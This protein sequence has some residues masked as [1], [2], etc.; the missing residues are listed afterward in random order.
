MKQFFLICLCAFILYGCGINQRALD[1]QRRALASDYTEPH[2]P[3]F[4]FTP[5]AKWMNDPNGMVYFDGEYHLFYQY[6]PDST[7]WGPMHWG[8]AVSEDLIHWEHLPIA[9]YPDER[10][11]IF[12]GSAVIDERNSSGLGIANM[13]PMVAI[14]T[15]HD[16]ES[17]KAGKID[18]QTQGIAYS[19]NDG[20]D[21]NKYKEN[22]VLENPGIE[23]FRN[24]KVMWYD[25]N[26]RWV[27]SLAVKDKISFY[28]S[29]NLLD[30]EHTGDFGTDAGAHGGVWECPDL[31]PLK[32]EGS[33]EVKWVLLVSIN[34]GGPNKG[35]A[36]Q[37]FVGDFDGNEFIP[38]PDWPLSEEGVWIDYGRD[39]YAGVTWYMGP[40]GDKRRIFMGWMSN[41]DYANEVPTKT[42]RSAMTIPR[43]L[44]LAETEYGLRL[45]SEPVPELS[46]LYKT[47]IAIQSQPLDTAIYFSRNLKTNTPTFDLKLQLEALSQDSDFYLELS[48]AQDQKVLIG[49]DGIR[50]QYYIDRTASGNHD[51]SDEFSGVQWGPRMVNGSNFDLRFL[52]DVASVEFFADGGKTTMTSI[53]FPDET[54]TSIRLHSKNGN[55]RIANG[56]FSDIK[57]MWHW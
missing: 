2:R 17:E 39:N 29:H 19:L 11:M 55:M 44:S 33:D 18:Y 16:A 53:F 15:Y 14:F 34:P 37:Y 23:D 46:R 47:T 51:F 1:R 40:N 21:W 41:W 35:S 9:L 25:Q 52:V 27:M 49:Y 30:W 7:I 4:H 56:E 6:H 22:P 3:H 42:W 12:S 5:P 54:F 38:D 20:R 28:S 26:K 45:V 24:P 13:P 50:Q 48:N 57:P 36:T 8:H 31:F 43:I 32:V 10:G